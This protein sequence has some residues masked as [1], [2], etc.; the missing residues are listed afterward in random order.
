MYSKILNFMFSLQNMGIF[1]TFEYKIDEKVTFN[2]NTQY[3]HK[4][5]ANTDTLHRFSRHC[6]PSDHPQKTESWSLQG[7]C[8]D[9]LLF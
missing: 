3:L 9:Q 1:W 6:I 4:S 7:T 2:C 8:V 5:V